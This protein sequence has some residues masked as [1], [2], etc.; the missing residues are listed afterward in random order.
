MIAV[1]DTGFVVALMN[2][3]D[4]AHQACHQV[5]LQQRVIYLPQTALTE[6]AYLLHREAGISS[7]VDFLVKLPRT[8]FVVT[9]LESDD[10]RR[11]AEI[12][13]TYSDSRVDFVDASVASLAERLQIARLLTLDRRDFHM[14]RPSHTEH[15]ELLP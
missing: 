8:K 10:I 4:R 12:L 11:A 14:M 2:R 1:A 13:S 7:V 3:K 9:G 6:I 5:Y 15:F